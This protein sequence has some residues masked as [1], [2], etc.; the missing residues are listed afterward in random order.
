MDVRLVQQW[1]QGLRWAPGELLEVLA[2]ETVV[3]SKEHTVLHSLALLDALPQPNLR[4]WLL[5][6]AKE[7]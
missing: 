4:C 2:T 7:K 3:S 5:Q 6:T 1:E